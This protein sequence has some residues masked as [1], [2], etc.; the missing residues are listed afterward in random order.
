MKKLLPKLIL[1]KLIMSAAAFMLIAGC[2]KK[3]EP[4]FKIH[5]IEQNP[6]LFEDD[7]FIDESL[8]EDT[9]EDVKEESSETDILENE[10]ES[11]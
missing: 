10:E 1:I 2:P 3:K 8:P 7:E 11:F 9:G 4:D 6:V 5:P